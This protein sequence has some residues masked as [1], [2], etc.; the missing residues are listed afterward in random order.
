MSDKEKLIK[1]IMVHLQKTHKIKLWGKYWHGKMSMIYYL[2]E[3]IYRNYAYY[4]NHFC[5]ILIYAWRYVCEKGL[6]SNNINQMLSSGSLW[7]WA[8]GHKGRACCLFSTVT[9]TQNSARHIWNTKFWRSLLLI[10]SFLQI[11]Q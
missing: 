11:L 1:Q 5:E 7:C 3:K 6:Y 9:L 10:Y 8:T 4:I 2:K